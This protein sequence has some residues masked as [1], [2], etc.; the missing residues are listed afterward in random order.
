MAQTL[1]D[2]LKNEVNKVSKY[3]I[4]K[5]S[6]EYFFRDP[7]RPVYI[8]YQNFYSP[9]D[10]VII[11]QKVIENPK[12]PVVEVKGVYYAL[13]DV[14]GDD[15]YNKPSLVIGI[16]MT[17]YDVHIN[18]IPYAGRL[19][20]KFLDS[21]ES[22]NKPMLAVEKDLLNKVIN[23]NNMDYIKN[24]E[25]MW[26]KIYAPM[27]DYSYYLIQIADEDVDVICHFEKDQNES[28][29][30][31]DRF[32]LVRWGS[33][34]DLILPLDDRYNFEFCQEVGMHVNAGL[35]KLVKINFKNPDFLIK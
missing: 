12:D 27:L 11:Y 8:D 6:N 5:L 17:F 32:S 26:N 20:Y 18:R 21:I 33:Q 2:W 35:D 4:G 16:F 28:Y 7:S 10:G 25:R 24:N 31:N 30:Q 3:S 19:K 13:S 9:A 34:V 23:P 22:E 1:D 14:I 29:S 15:S